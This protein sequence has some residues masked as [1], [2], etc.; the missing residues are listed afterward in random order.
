[1]SATKRRTSKRRPAA[2]QLSRRWRVGPHSDAA[3]RA[4]TTELVR[5]TLGGKPDRPELL[6]DAAGVE[7]AASAL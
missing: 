2:P 7:P 3:H 4:I 6:V 1:M 5:L